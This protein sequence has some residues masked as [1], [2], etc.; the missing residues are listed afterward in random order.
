MAKSTA[1]PTS[2][3]TE[4]TPPTAVGDLVPDPVVF[5]EFGITPMTGWRWDHDPALIDLG[6]PPPLV[7]RKRKFRVRSQL[8]AF[9]ARMLARAL[10][11]RPERQKTE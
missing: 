4:G 11:G 1:R 8:E 10:T 6:W 3:P 5:K 2:N 9:K 7:I